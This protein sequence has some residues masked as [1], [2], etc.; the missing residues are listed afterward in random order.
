MES[1]EPL[2]NDPAGNGDDSAQIKFTGCQKTQAGRIVAHRFQRTVRPGHIGAAHG[3]G[4]G[5]RAIA[6]NAVRINGS[7]QNRI[8]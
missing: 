7:F 6:I 4:F 5:A 1:A 8:R 2:L 3:H